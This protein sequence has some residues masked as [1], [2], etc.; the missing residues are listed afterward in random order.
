MYALVVHRRAARYLGMLPQDQQ[1][2]IKQ[3]LNEMRNDPL[4]ISGIKPMAGDWAG[5]HRVRVGNVRVI[6]W[7]DKDKNLIFVDHIGP[8]G[9]LYKGGA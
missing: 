7:I 5:Y 9:D 1:A 6:F 4:A 2:K 8:R 3:V